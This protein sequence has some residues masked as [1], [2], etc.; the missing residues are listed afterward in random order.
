MR[1]YSPMNEFDHG[2]TQWEMVPM[3]PDQRAMESRKSGPGGGSVEALL[4]TPEDAAAVLGVGRV[5]VYE[6]IRLRV[7]PSVKIGRCR[8]VA[9]K[10]LREY[11]DRLLAAEAS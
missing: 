9:V 7:L 4:L 6:L 8:R 2:D 3:R 1:R 10:S 5:T 11:V